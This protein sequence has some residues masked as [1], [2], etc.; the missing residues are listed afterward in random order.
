MSKIFSKYVF[1]SCIPFVLILLSIALKTEYS[2][3]LPNTPRVWIQNSMERVMLDTPP[4]DIK[5]VHLYAARGEY[6]SFQIAINAAQPDITVANVEVSDLRSSDRSIARN[7]ITLYREHYVNVTKPSP[8]W[9]GTNVKPLGKGWYP[10]GLIPF[11]DPQTETELVDA[12]LDAVPFQLEPRKN[13]PIW[14]DIFVPK[15]T[16]PGDYRGTY[17][18]SSSTGQVSGKVELTVWNFELPVKP[19]LKSA[20]LLW[21]Q[22]DKNT[23]IELLKHRIMPTGKINPEDEREL[24]DRWGLSSVR[25]PFWSGANHQTCSMDAA[26]TSKEI[27]KE[28]LKHQLDLIPYVYATDEIDDCKGLQKPF[29]EWSENIHQAGVKHLAVMS[30]VPEFYDLVDIWAVNPT[31]YDA[32][33]KKIAEVLRQGKEIWFYTFFVFG[34]NEPVWQ[35]DFK[36]INHRIAQGFINQSLG[37][38]GFLYW[39]ADNWT[40]DPW[41]D[42][43]TNPHPDEPQHHPG[44]GMLI[45]PGEQVGVNG[46]VPSM[47]LKW[48]RE[49]VE[50][51]EYIEILKRWGDRDWAMATV[52]EVARDFRHWNQDSQALIRARQKLGEKIDRLSQSL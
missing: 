31:R 18:V 4:Q 19:S 46:S 7:N 9:G 29:R 13:Q 6:E 27:R 32:A 45:Y 16:P 35:I 30:P 43:D 15:D 21:E 51:Y 22:Q 40:D 33:G 10:D 34:G 5:D 3:S 26:P 42:V 47:R 44:E 2:N 17:T 11:V 14:V 37:L 28:G 39:R 24:I 12:Q 48:I 52:R 49:G 1:W 36:P 41:N 20:F 23:Q 38:T 25:L 50:D 8:T